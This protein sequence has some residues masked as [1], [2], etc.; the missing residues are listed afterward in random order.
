MSKRIFV[1]KRIMAVVLTVVIFV[2]APSISVCASDDSRNLITQILDFLSDKPLSI[3]LFLNYLGEGKEVA[4]WEEEVYPHIK[5]SILDNADYQSKLQ[6]VLKLAY[7]NGHYKIDFIS[8]SMPPG[9][10]EPSFDETRYNQSFAFNDGD[11]FYALHGINGHLVIDAT[12]LGGQQF[13]VWVAVSD[14]YDFDLNM[15]C[16][17]GNGLA[18][19]GNNYMTALKELYDIGNEFRVTMGFTYSC[20]WEMPEV[21]DSSTKEIASSPTLTDPQPPSDVSTQGTPSSPGGYVTNQYYARGSYD[22]GYYTGEW[23]GGK[24]NGQGTLVYEG[25]TKYTI[26]MTNGDIYSASTF[27][28][29]WLDGKKYGY[30][31]FTFANG[32]QY[33]GVWN[34]DGYYFKGNVIFPAYKQYI[35]QIAYGDDIQT[36]Y[37]EEPIYNQISNNDPDSSEAESEKNTSSDP[38][39][40]AVEEGSFVCRFSAEKIPVYKSAASSEIR[41]YV[42]NERDCY[43]MICDKKYVLQDGSVRYSHC[44]GSGDDEEIVGEPDSVEIEK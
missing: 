14:Y 10:Y 16:Y 23:K 3:D 21:S 17:A 29:N 4:Y 37:S 13:D 42:I 15:Q 18:C 19:F 5:R 31:V 26:K 36:V 8:D 27:T 43:T 12:Y 20:F 30:G 28:G 6:D 40:K 7:E 11:L 25:G 22:I 35:E 2:S 33:D 34:V 32:I 24:P 39:V 1:V 9:Y 38:A 41:Y 44:I